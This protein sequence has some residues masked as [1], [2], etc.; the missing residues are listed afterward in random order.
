MKGDQHGHAKE[1]TSEHRCLTS[2]RGVMGR[3]PEF[4]RSG[5]GSLH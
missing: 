4:Q 1:E 3:S 2:T 5:A